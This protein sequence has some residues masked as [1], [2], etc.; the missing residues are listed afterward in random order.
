VL[1]GSIDAIKKST[2][3]DN[4][5]QEGSNKTN[6]LFGSITPGSLFETTVT[7]KSPTAD[8]EAG[9]PK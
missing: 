6:S 9:K 8:K 4:K 3:E 7:P 1:N 2:S 5:P